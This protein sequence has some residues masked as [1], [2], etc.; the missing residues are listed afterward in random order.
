MITILL[1][2]TANAE[3]SILQT[4]LFHGDEVV[5]PMGSS[6]W[7]A[8]AEGPEG[9]MAGWVD[10]VIDRA[11]DPVVDGA[12][13]ATGVRVSV[14]GLDSVLLLVRG[15]DGLTEGRL[16]TLEIG[17]TPITA[18]L[19]LGVFTLE[20]ADPPLALLLKAGEVVQTLATPKRTPSGPWPVL[21]WAGDW[22]GDGRPD[23]LLD[24]ADHPNMDATTLFLSSRATGTQLVAPVAT[25]VTT[26]C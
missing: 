3:P 5:V 22:D 15:I 4:G 10:V 16:T 26:G 17:P 13:E 19:A 7:M 8:L 12:G 14:P 1:A 18:P 6:K 25:L 9:A 11:C 23:L 2:L 20:V 24:L 21:L